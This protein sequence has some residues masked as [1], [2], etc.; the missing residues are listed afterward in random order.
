MMVF[1]IACSVKTVVLCLYQG[2]H[3]RLLVMVEMWEVVVC[4]YLLGKIERPSS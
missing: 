4:Q 1:I 2:V 3:M